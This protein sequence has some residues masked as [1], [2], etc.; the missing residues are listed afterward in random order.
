MGLLD[1]F[2]A[3]QGSVKK[4]YKIDR[5]CQKLLVVRKGLQILNGQILSSLPEVLT[6]E[7]TTSSNN[8]QSICDRVQLGYLAAFAQFGE[9]V[10]PEKTIIRNGQKNSEAY[11]PVLLGRDG[12]SVTGNDNYTALFENLIVGSTYDVYALETPTTGVRYWEYLQGSILGGDHQ[13]TVDL[14]AATAIILPASAHISRATV[15]FATTEGDKIADY[16]LEELRFLN[17]EENDIEIQTTNFDSDEQ[18]SPRS[19]ISHGS[20]F[21]EAIVLMLGPIKHITF[22]TDGTL[23]DFVTVTERARY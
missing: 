3:Q 21:S 4:K 18:G 19:T 8:R 9:G 15:T 12:Q 20:M 5:N 1:T 2:T 7:N 17:A 22:H 11:L 16:T 10:I 13:K 14:D 6:V 23:V